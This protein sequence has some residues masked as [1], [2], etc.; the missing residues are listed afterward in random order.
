MM[1]AFHIERAYFKALGKLI[2]GSVVPD[3]LTDTDAVA[4]R[5][6][7]VFITRKKL[8]QEQEGSSN[9]GA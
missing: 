2:V 3:I 7:N 5:S 8:Q 6:L 9:L 1:G 4:P